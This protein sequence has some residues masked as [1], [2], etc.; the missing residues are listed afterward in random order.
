MRNRTL[1][2]IAAGA[3]AA[4]PAF[5]GRPPA[6]GPGGHERMEGLLE[7]R[8]ERLADALELTAEQR[9]TFDRLRAE[10]LA[11]AEPAREQM[12]AGH[13]ELRTLLDGA[14]P[15][16]AEVGA[17]MIE[18]HRLHGELRA[19]RDKFERDLEATLSD[20]QKLAWKAV[21][22]T[23]PGERLRERLGRR[24]EGPGHFGPPSA[25]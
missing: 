8:S 18:I 17:K 20:A 22:E 3:L 5:A 6:P 21:R 7:M 16:A 25:N 9:A 19:A 23:R 14:N 2:W 1:A 12:R 13:D 11:A 24:G 10:A 4:L 15:D